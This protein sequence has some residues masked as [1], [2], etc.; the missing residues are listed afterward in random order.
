METIFDGIQRP[1]ETIAQVSGSVFVPRGIDLPCLNQDKLYDFTP[2][3]LSQGDIIAGGDQLGSVFE[4]DLFSK[5]KIMAN[6]KAQ[7]RLVEVSP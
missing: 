4:N 2:Q 1:L 3:A 7:G 5:H 6:P